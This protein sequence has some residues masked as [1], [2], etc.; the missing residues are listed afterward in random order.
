MLDPY[1]PGI[2]TLAYQQFITLKGQLAVHAQA[3]NSLLQGAEH[4]LLDLKFWAA[5]PG[6]AQTPRRAWLF[7][8]AQTEA[9]RCEV[10]VQ[11]RLKLLG[12]A[13]RDLMIDV[14]DP[15]PPSARPGSQ[16]QVLSIA[17]G[18][19]PDAFYPLHNVWLVTTAAAL[20]VPARQL[21]VVLYAFGEEG[22]VLGF[23][24]LEAL[25]RSV[26]A[27]LGSRDGSVLWRCVEHDKRSDLRAHALRETLAVRYVPIDG[28]P[29]LAALKKLL[30]CY[31]RL[32]KSTEDITRIFSEVTEVGFS[33]AL[34]LAALAQQL[35][36]PANN[37][38]S[39]AQAN[40]D[41]LRKAA[42][43]ASCCL[44]RG[45]ITALATPT[46]RSMWVL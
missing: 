14:L 17:V 27:S 42:S 41:L 25:T 15:P 7:M 30:G 6:G 11:H 26:K 40:I 20:R 32:H 10:Q 8:H 37:A 31:D 2:E 44:W 12:T 33:R 5:R 16:T 36:V 24:G 18:S 22:G 39:Q 38:L 43:D 29:A 21:P 35:K 19:E 46:L 1:E 34:L 28:K 23:A 13:H 3:L 45:A 9:M 4:R